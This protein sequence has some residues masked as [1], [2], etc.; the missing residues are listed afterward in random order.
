[1]TAGTP[2]SRTS[3]ACW[4]WPRSPGVGTR[5]GTAGWPGCEHRRQSG[6]GYD[7]RGPPGV[8]SINQICT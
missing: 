5:G 7:P 6:E 1:V 2:S 8:N 4:G 3:R